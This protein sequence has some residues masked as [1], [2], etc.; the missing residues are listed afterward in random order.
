[1]V[2]WLKADI[3]GRWKNV[4]ACTKFMQMTVNGSLSLH[5]QI[6]RSNNAAIV[7]QETKERYQQNMAVNGYINYFQMVFISDLSWITFLYV[8]DIFALPVMISMKIDRSHET[9]QDQQSKTLNKWLKKPNFV[10]YPDEDIQMKP[11]NRFKCSADVTKSTNGNVSGALDEI[12][13]CAFFCFIHFQ[14]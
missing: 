2:S 12:F 1:V 13:L 9:I 14:E 3:I 10:D 11:E 4:P 5:C 6:L 7:M 8:L